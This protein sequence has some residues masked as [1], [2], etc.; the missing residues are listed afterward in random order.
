[1]AW[2]KPDY[3]Q[4]SPQ[5]TIMSAEKQFVLSINNLDPPAKLA[6]FSIFDGIKW[7]TVNST[8]PIGG[9]WTNIAATFNGSSMS[10]YVNGTLQSSL[11]PQQC[12]DNTG[13]WQDW[14]KDSRKRNLKRQHS[15]RCVL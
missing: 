14:D 3:T 1:M 10:L 2:V 15:H 11:E 8:V 6:T 13:G 4:G 9:N 5:F 12:L 7:D